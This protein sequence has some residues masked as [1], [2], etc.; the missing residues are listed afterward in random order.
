MSHAEP[1][2][3]PCAFSPG[4]RSALKEARFLA[5][6]F[7]SPGRVV[8]L[9]FGQ[10]HFL[11][12]AA[13]RGLTAIG[14]DLDQALVLGAISRGYEAHCMDVR[15]FDVAIAGMLDG[16][17]AQHLIEHLTPT[18][19]GRL[20]STLA[21]KVRPGGAGVLVTPNFRDWRVASEWFWHDASHLRPYTEGTIRG[22]LDPREWSLVQAGLMPETIDRHTP[23]VWLHRLRFGRHYGRSG[24]WFLLRRAGEAPYG[25]L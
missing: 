9:G 25:R 16:F 20:L 3:D 10:G 5:G 11:D 2:R 23:G 19:T 6:L 13:E 12:A 18:E 21:Q 1:L 17:L 8:D 24:R 15:E 22:I 4:L 7:P 14:I